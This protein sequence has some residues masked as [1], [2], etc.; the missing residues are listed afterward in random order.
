MSERLS[1]MWLIQ[2]FIG[3]FLIATGLL[4]LTGN[5]EVAKGMSKMLGKN[6][7][8]GILIAIIELISG[9]ILLVGLFIGAQQK[10]MFLACVAIFVLWS[11]N[12]LSVYFFNG[13]FKPN[14]MV[15]IRDLSLHLIVLSGLWGV[16]LG[17]RG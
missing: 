11:I 12:I 7:T 5:S 1:A 10:W 4:F 14:F 17:S 15:W 3:I 9:F 6:N 13:F 16:M 2:L 8:W